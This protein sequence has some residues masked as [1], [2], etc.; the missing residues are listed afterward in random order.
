LPQASTAAIFPY[1]RDRSNRVTYGLASG[2]YDTFQSAMRQVKQ[3][4]E[5]LI[6]DEPW[7]RS[8]PTLKRDIESFN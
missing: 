3:L 2:V 7:I 5:S 8:V 4:P 1:K 6:E